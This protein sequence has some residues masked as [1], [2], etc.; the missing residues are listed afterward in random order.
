[1]TREIF[2][3][4][5]KIVPRFGADKRA[6]AHVDFLALAQRLVE[7]LS[8]STNEGPR[9]QLGQELACFLRISLRK[10]LLAVLGEPAVLAGVSGA[11]FVYVGC[12][13]ELVLEASEGLHLRLN[14]GVP[15]TDAT[16]NGRTYHW[17]LVSTLRADALRGERWG[18]VSARVLLAQHG[19]S[20]RQVLLGCVD[21]AA[22][23]GAGL[24]L[25][26]IAASSLMEHGHEV[27]TV[28]LACQG[29]VTGETGPPLAFD[30]ALMPALTRLSLDVGELSAVLRGYCDH[31]AGVRG[32]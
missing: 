18:E 19:E 20:S 14:L 11:G 6:R 17:R 15:G 24:Y 13:Y 8:A 1:M 22:G 5:A 28:T 4:S 2:E 16:A 10:A 25:I 31:L 30:D 9:P 27:L 29:V 21:E 3:V 7:L 32:V 23:G 12:F 26:N